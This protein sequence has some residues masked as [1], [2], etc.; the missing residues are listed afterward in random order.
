M[1]W[2]GPAL[3]NGF[4][5]AGSMWCVWFVLHYPGI[6][7]S[8][9]V[10]GILILLAMCLSGLLCGRQLPRGTD[11]L[12]TGACSGLTASCINL[13]VLMSYLTSTA[14]SSVETPDAAAQAAL[15]PS[16]P[17]IVI[18]F[19]LF[20]AVVGAVTHFVGATLAPRTNPPIEAGASLPSSAQTPDW[21]A[22]F[23]AVAAILIVPLLL[24]GA[25]V[26]SSG[27][28]LAVPDWPS[29]YGA[30][31]IMYPIGLMRQ[32]IV[33]EHGHRLFGMLIGL[34]TVVLMLQSLLSKRPLFVKFWAVGL[35]VLVSIQ[36]V[37][38]GA[39]VVQQSA[40]LSAM[41]GVLAQ[42]FFALTV[43]YA[44]F[45]SP[46]FRNLTT[47]L[48][49]NGYAAA[50]LSTLFGASND[51]PAQ[52]RKLKMFATAATHS[53]VLQLI[54][55][56]LYRHLRVSHALWAHIGFSIIVVIM[57]GGA[58]FVAQRLSAEAASP[59]IRSTL[60]RLG[61]GIVAIVFI[62]FLLGWGAF[63]VVLTTDRK[64][65][66]YQEATA[67]SD[68][69]VYATL[70]PTIHQANG[71]ALLA[72]STMTYVWAFRLKRVARNA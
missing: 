17:Q 10:Q 59:H 64:V 50:P 15:H 19:L 40:T 3:V 46:L 13:L 63:W 65:T 39:R 12:I 4:T 69:P 57:A 58:G 49:G 2:I 70:I 41:H 18:G 31:M 26:T 20:G 22:R 1:R 37:L 66:T 24:V 6:N 61:K 27:S 34:T 23:A 55:G 60:R 54:F 52:V 30:S 25:L 42:V 5:M 7:A 38:G 33:I 72:F 62:Q 11:A 35:F 28:G 14:S 67:K 36:G 71:A 21:H 44:T 48:T 16:T 51:A 45:V 56:A 53:I 8:P 32:K 9:S 29:T 68:L 43:A 47:P